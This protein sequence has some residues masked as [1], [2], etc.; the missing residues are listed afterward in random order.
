M[1]TSKITNGAND[2]PKDDTI[3]QTGDGIPDDSGAP[4]DVSDE[5]VERT[6]NKLR[7]GTSHE[8]LMNEVEEEIDLPTKG[9][10]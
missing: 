9:S 4:I 6:R 1:T 2:R 3:A 7:G 10:A 5:E 8:D